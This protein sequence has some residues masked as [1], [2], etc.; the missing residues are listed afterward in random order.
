MA[1]LR[2]KLLLIHVFYMKWTR[3]SISKRYCVLAR[4]DLTAAL[5]PQYNAVFLYKESDATTNNGQ[6]DIITKLKEDHSCY[7]MDNKQIKTALKYRIQLHTKEENIYSSS[8]LQALI[9][10]PLINPSPLYI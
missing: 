8:N 2:N 4:V 6:L 7:H 10:S 5:T 9:P 1:V 3:D